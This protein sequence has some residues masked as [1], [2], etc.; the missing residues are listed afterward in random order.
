MAAREVVTLTEV[1]FCLSWFQL[2]RVVPENG[3]L[4][5]VFLLDRSVKQKQCVCH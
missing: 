5:G 1:Y 4:M 2:T 3:Q